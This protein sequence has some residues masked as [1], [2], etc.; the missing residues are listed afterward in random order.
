MLDISPRT[1]NKYLASGRIA[2]TRNP[3]SGTWSIPD[4]ALHS[5]LIGQGLDPSAFRVPI[6]VLL[7]DDD[8]AVLRA[9]T[10]M[11][12]RSEYDF[13]VDTCPDGYQALIRLGGGI[14]DVVVLD[15]RMPNVNGH[16]VLRAIRSEERSA[17]A[18]VLVCS[19]FPGDLSELVAIGAN[20]S[21]KKPFD[22][23]DFVRKILA[24]LPERRVQQAVSR[25]A[26]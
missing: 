22:P 25:V 10:A 20:D 21:L 11:L 9:M 13:V 1:V 8:A 14:P 19:A 16:Q 12:E 4:E 5:F 18:K 15:S 6:S 17:K 24:L 7:V 26:V 2:G 23:D 3:I